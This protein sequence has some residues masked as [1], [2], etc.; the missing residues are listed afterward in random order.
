[1]KRTTP[2]KVLLV[3]GGREYQDFDTLNAALFA[4]QKKH[5][6]ALLVQGG[7]PGADWM[8]KSWAMTRS[9]QTCTFEANWEALGKSAGPKRNEAMSEF[10][11][12]EAAVAF[13]GGVGTEGMCRILERD[14]ARVWRVPEGWRP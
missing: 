2:G 8:A 14:G 4:V 9:I 3:C 11:A 6:I 10:I 12:I 1:M 13:P 7:A 5:G